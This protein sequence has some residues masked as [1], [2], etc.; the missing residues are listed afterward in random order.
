MLNDKELAQQQADLLN[1]HCGPLC[2]SGSIRRDGGK[3]MSV[4]VVY[5]RPGKQPSTLPSWNPEGQY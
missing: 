1:F 2:S 3:Q 5:Q 4:T